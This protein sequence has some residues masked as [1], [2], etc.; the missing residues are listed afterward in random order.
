ML[1]MSVPS[2]LIGMIGGGAG[3][4]GA[5]RTMSAGA[6]DDVTAAAELVGG[7]TIASFVVVAAATTAGADED[8]WVATSEVAL[9]IATEEMASEEDE[10]AA[11]AGADAAGAL[12]PSTITWPWTLVV[13]S[14]E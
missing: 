7:A 2:V 1:S 10:T 6:M 8:V 4:L 12:G 3:L 13:V 5:G 14:E 9:D 11:I